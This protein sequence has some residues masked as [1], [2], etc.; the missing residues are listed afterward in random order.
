MDADFGFN[1]CRGWPYRLK[2]TPTCRRNDEKPCIFLTAINHSNKYK[3]RNLKTHGFPPDEVATFNTPNG[4]LFKL[5]FYIF[6]YLGTGATE[7]G[8]QYLH[9]FIL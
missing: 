8:Q 9:T 4:N 3:G 7:M 5:N 6:L 2:S 1:L